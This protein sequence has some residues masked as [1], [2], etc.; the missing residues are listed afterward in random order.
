MALDPHVAVLF[1]LTT[2]GGAWMLV[3]G[4]HKHALEWRRRKRV[5]PSCGRQVHGRACG[6]N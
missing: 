4:V 3:A 6:C 2:A 1:L 5:C